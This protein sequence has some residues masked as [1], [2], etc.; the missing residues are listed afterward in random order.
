MNELLRELGVALNFGGHSAEGCV[1]ARLDEFVDGRSKHGPEVPLDVSGVGEF[2]RGVPGAHARLRAIGR[3]RR[4]EDDR[5]FGGPPAIE[6]LLSDARLRGDPFDREARVAVAEYEL[7]SCGQDRLACGGATSRGV[8]ERASAAARR[9][10]RPRRTPP[11][12]RGRRRE[13]PAFARARAAVRERLAAA[14][15]LAAP[16]SLVVAIA[17]SGER[18]GAMD[19]GRERAVVLLAIVLSGDFRAC[20]E[21]S[22]VPRAGRS[23]DRGDRAL[24]RGR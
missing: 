4:V 23:P 12:D 19:S 22:S 10:R 9:R 18:L 2:R 7:T 8:R 3:E 16:L 24:L 11:R 15:L 21:R 5:S 6:R 20:S 14:S 13:D 1:E 17:S